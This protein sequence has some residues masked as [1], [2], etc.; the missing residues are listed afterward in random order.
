MTSVLIML[1]LISFLIVVH[2]MGHY[3]VARWCG[4]KVERF[5]FGLPIGPTLWKKKVGDTEFCLHPLLFGGYVAFPDDNP[6]SLTSPRI[7]Q[8][9]LKTVPCGN[10][11]PLPVLALPLTL[12]WLGP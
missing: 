5:G 10:G 3:Y 8:N 11:L 7:R 6:D 9:G 1:A 4:V 2:E 12:W